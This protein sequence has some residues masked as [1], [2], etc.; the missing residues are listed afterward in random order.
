MVQTNCMRNSGV[1]DDWI[2]RACAANPIRETSERSF[3]T[4][5]IR[6]ANSSLFVATTYKGQQGQQ[7]QGQPQEAKYFL[8]GLFTP[9]SDLQPMHARIYQ[10]AQ[11]AFP[12][13]CVNGQIYGVGLPFQDQGKLGNKAGYTPGLPMFRP[14]SKEQYKPT[15]YDRPPAINRI[16]TA[17]QGTPFFYPGAWVMAHVT[18]FTNVPNRRI[19]AGVNAV[20]AFADDEKLPG[21]GPDTDALVKG[22]GFQAI[23]SPVAGPQSGGFQGVPGSAGPNYQGGAPATYGA[24]TAPFGAPPAPA[25]LYA[26]AGAGIAPNGTGYALNAAPSY[27]NA[28]PAYAGAPA[29][30]PLSQEAMLAR[31]M[32]R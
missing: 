20:V 27:G 9:Y 26:G 30:P 2:A 10:M 7:Q 6:V 31:L 13:A 14:K 1:G 8:T 5:P 18:F 29:Q 22:G 11:G 12:D 28:A 16:F 25:N 17:E 23:R 32:G 19:A 15:I 24:S 21:G 4:G 3:W